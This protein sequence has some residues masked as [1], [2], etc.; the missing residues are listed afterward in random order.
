MD[1]CSYN[2]NNYLLVD[3]NSVCTL[4]C[5]L[6]EKSFGSIYQKNESNGNKCLVSQDCAANSYW[7]RC[8]IKQISICISVVILPSLVTQ[9]KYLCNVSNFS[10]N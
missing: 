8:L 7:V 5:V 9:D 2:M 1:I 3:Q 4:T 6:L 10:A